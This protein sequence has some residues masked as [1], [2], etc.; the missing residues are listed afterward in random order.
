MDL[1]QREVKDTVRD[2]ILKP[3]YLDVLVLLCSEFQTWFS[4]AELAR[5][6]HSEA[7]QVEAA[8][9]HFEAVH[10]IERS[11][12]NGHATYRYAPR[13]AA[14]ADSVERLMDAFNRFPVQLLRIV[15]DLPPSPVRNFSNPSRR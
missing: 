6:V 13:T 7:T 12:V 5:A 3:V 2:W 1:L 15:Y 9:V 4:V 14:L 8:L 11:Q 10:L